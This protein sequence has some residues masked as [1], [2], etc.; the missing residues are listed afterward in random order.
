MCRGYHVSARNTMCTGVNVLSRACIL[1]FTNKRHTRASDTQHHYTTFFAWQI[2]LRNFAARAKTDVSAIVESLCALRRVCEVSH[3]YIYVLFGAK[4]ENSRYFER[5]YVLSI[6]CK[7]RKRF[8]RKWWRSLSYRMVYRFFNS[9]LKV[10]AN[11]S[12]VALP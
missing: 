6:T 12:C 7:R 2:R 11:A 4:C 3:H 1:R 8:L 9:I 10:F 5:F